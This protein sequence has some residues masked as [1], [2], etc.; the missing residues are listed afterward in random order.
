M[1]II[2]SRTP[3]PIL[4]A[5]TT[6]YGLEYDRYCAVA[7]LSQAQENAG[8]VWRNRQQYP[9]GY[10]TGRW[11]ALQRLRRCRAAVR[12]VEAELAEFARRKRN[13]HAFWDDVLE[14]AQ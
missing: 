2:T 8:I 14:A 13:V 3:G 11:L 7:A 12:R 4:A 9:A 10:S 6:R 1:Q 5:L